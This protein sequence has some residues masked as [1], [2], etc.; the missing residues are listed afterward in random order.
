M[1]HLAIMVAVEDPAPN[2]ESLQELVEKIEIT[3]PR[4]MSVDV[5]VE[6]TNALHSVL[7]RT[8]GGNLKRRR[9]THSVRPAH[10]PVL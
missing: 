7:T 1:K 2:Y 4:G 3:L 5:V 6:L 9:E 10:Q 8:R